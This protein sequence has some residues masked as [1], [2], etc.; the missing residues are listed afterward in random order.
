MSITV[1]MK[2]VNSTN[3]AHQFLLPAPSD[4]NATRSPS[5]T[6]DT[7]SF[8]HSGR[9]LSFSSENGT[10]DRGVTNFNIGMAKSLPFS[11]QQDMDPFNSLLQPFD[12][13]E[14]CNVLVISE[15]SML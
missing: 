15:F 9:R 7:A 6:K 14:G 11:V 3:I 8:L 1:W 5:T 10:S 2:G 13:L 4:G 12:N